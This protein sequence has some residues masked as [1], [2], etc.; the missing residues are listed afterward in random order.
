MRPELSEVEGIS[1]M[2]FLSDNTQVKALV[3]KDRKLN[4]KH[5]GFTKLRLKLLC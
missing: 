2:T 5:M 1:K 4:F 3:V